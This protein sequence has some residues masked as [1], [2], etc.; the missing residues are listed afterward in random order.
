MNLCFIGTSVLT[1]VFAGW[2]ADVCLGRKI[3]VY[4][5]LF[6]HFL[7]YCP[8]LTGL[9]CNLNRFLLKF[10][11]YYHFYLAFSIKCNKSSKNAVSIY[12]ICI[13]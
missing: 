3:L 5:C 4:M 11:A 8:L 6:L 9:F 10:L 7:G 12:F 13:I 1:P 2:F